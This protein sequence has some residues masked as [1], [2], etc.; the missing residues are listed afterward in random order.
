[1]R[2]FTNHCWC[3]DSNWGGT[4]DC[5][6]ILTIEQDVD[7]DFGEL[8]TA[9]KFF[10]QQEFDM[11]SEMYKDTPEYRHLI[12]SKEMAMRNTFRLSPNVLQWLSDN[13]LPRKGFDINEG[14]AIGTDEYNRTS[15][16]Q[17]AFDIFFHRK[18]DLM[19]FIKEFSK[20]KKPTVYFD[21]FNDTRKELN[22]K[23]LKYKTENE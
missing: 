10:S 6:Y 14:W 11:L 21:Y 2:Y 13:V 4:F 17:G 23:T 18:R 15:Y 8:L 9:T 22:L 19:N 1:M 20:Y 3:S 12:V 5:R 7:P 16:P